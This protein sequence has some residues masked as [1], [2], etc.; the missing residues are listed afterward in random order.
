[1]Y[2]KSDQLSSKFKLSVLSADCSCWE[3]EGQQVTSSNLC[4]SALQVGT[5][6]QNQNM[7]QVIN[8]KPPTK[9]YRAPLFLIIFFFWFN[10]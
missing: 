1:M 6:P 5:F 4:L 8:R 10:N 7:Q 2:K 3:I 9:P